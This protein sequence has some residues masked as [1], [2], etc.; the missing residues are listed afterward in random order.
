MAGFLPKM[1]AL[2]NLDINVFAAGVGS[3][4]CTESGIIDVLASMALKELCVML[5]M[6]VGLL[7]TALSRSRTITSLEVGSVQADD[8]SEWDPQEHGYAVPSLYTNTDTEGSDDDD[9]QSDNDKIVDD[10]EQ[11]DGELVDLASGIEISEPNDD[12]GDDGDDEDETD[13]DNDAGSE[14]DE[15]STA[16]A[17]ESDGSDGTGGSDG[18]NESNWD[19]DSAD[20]SEDDVD[21]KRGH[22]L[23]A[24]L[25]N[26][27][28]PHLREFQ[29]RGDHDCAPLVWAALED[30]L[31]RFN[32]LENFDCDGDL[33]RETM[34]QVW[35]MTTMMVHGQT[36]DR[37]PLL[38]RNKLLQARMHSAALR[39]CAVGRLLLHSRALPLPVELR[40]K[41]VR[42]ASGDAAA[43]SEAQW[44]RL[45]EHLGD[46]MSGAMESKEAWLRSLGLM[47]WETNP[48]ENIPDVDIT[49]WP[50]A[51]SEWD[52]EHGSDCHEHIAS[53]L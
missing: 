5:P 50:W 2:R 44:R 52:E 37:C 23:S 7:G 8:Y 39:A 25:N 48:D 30:F 14:D 41:I 24:F 38:S 12:A 36:D 6:D 28:L 32:K 21:I 20:E 27:R 17:D 15:D 4:D 22:Q 1:T 49:E 11:G 18:P 3:E 43:F 16:N 9:G 51:S 34:T 29:M 35:R 42:E 26:L 13:G 40:L 47:F 31:A 45:E 33:N 53:Y 46:E 19:D 10:A